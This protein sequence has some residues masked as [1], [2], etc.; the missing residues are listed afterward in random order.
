MLGRNGNDGLLGGN[1]R[2]GGKGEPGFPGMKG[3]NKFHSQITCNRTQ[4]Y[5][6]HSYRTFYSVMI[7]KH[8]HSGA[9][10]IRGESGS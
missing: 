5:F 10:R 4:I 7:I 1:G 6:I 3:T 8:W 2:D 9:E